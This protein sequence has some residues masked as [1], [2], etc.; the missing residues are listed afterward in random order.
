MDSD[1][2]TS[3]A[4]P[5]PSP[6]ASPS[7]SV[8]GPPSLDR[9]VGHFVA[10][11]RS[12][13]STSHVW[14]ANKVVTDSRAL[15]EEI[16]VLNAKNAFAR[17]GVEQNLEIL[18]SFR[19][20]LLQVRDK[21]GN[22]FEK[23]IA[24]LDEA[25]D[26]L[27]RT[28]EKLRKTV[29]DA[30]LQRSADE[31]AAENDEE[32]SPSA[33]PDESNDSQNLAPK[34]KTLFD[35]IDEHRHLDI[36]DALRSLI[37]S[38]RNAEREHTDITDA[39]HA[40]IQF[41]YTTLDTQTANSASANL[42]HKRT[43]YDEPSPSIPKL[44]RSLEDNA[45]EMATGL[46]NLIDHYDL[47][48]TAL[49]HTEGGGEAAKAAIQQADALLQ[50]NTPGAEESLYNKKIPEPMDDA[51]RIEM[52]RVLESDA[53]QVDEVNAEIK[54]LAEKI[55]KGYEA[56][57]RQVLDSR[58]THQNLRRVLTQLHE[59]KTSLPSHLSA[60]QHFTSAWSSIRSSIAEQTQ[61]LLDWDETYQ[62]FL[63]GYAALL[64]E[65][66]RRE[67]AE[68]QMKKV[69]VKAQKELD[70]LFEVDR[71]EREMFMERVGGDLPGDIWG[72]AGSR[73]RRWV[74]VQEEEDEE[75][76]QTEV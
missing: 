26:R 48:V 21:A 38:F 44:F 22:E 11:K 69:A 70:R 59:I 62:R 57:S 14:R 24:S 28:L 15:V 8:Q 36:L 35:F 33:T 65:R 32:R 47:C 27:Q 16:A 7:T 4:V 60:T 18:E 75:E 61:A 39:L 41:M 1:T 9:L 31:P 2:D 49:K 43:L 54:A 64:R 40:S 52:L 58:A 76:E 74:V 66:E 5:S 20:A 10:A 56:L 12:L 42:K 19:E 6:P 25:H 51:E 29:V 50:K 23:T 34:A 71:E 37:D 53:S 73:G 3:S 46:Q 63:K 67:V 17:N 30:S 72:D 68:T 13:T 55:E 45:T